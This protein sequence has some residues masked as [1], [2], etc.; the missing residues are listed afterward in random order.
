MALVKE[1]NLIQLK[2]R[3]QEVLNGIDHVKRDGLIDWEL[4]SD[5]HLALST[6]VRAVDAEIES[7]WKP[8]SI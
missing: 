1:I 7:Q 3:I 4:L 5:A 6:L 2:L 8:G